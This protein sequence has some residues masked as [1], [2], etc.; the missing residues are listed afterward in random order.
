VDVQGTA[1]GTPFS[2]EQLGRLLDLAEKGIAHLI[3]VQK[4]A[5]AQ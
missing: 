1:E 4:Q 2:R 5:L 3:E